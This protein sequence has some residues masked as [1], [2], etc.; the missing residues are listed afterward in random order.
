[1][2]TFPVHMDANFTASRPRPPTDQPT[3]DVP[4]QAASRL[5]SVFKNFVTREGLGVR[6]GYGTPKTLSN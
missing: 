6:F 2:L 1:M 3:S 4:L 5:E